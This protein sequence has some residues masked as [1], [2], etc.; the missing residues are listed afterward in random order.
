[1]SEIPTQ[2]WTC[3]DAEAMRFERAWKTG[4][5][6]QIEDFLANVPE[7]Q[8]SPLLTELLLIERELRVAAGELPT[9]KEYCR[10]FPEHDTVVA[11]AFERD[12]SARS[13]QGRETILTPSRALNSTTQAEAKEI[14]PEL[15]SNPDYEIVRSL[16]EGGMG[17]VYL[18]HNRVMGRDEVLKVIG[19][20]II[21]QPGVSDRFL[22]EI[23]AVAKLRHPNIVSAYSTFRCGESLVFAMEYVEGLDL[24]RLVKANGPLPIANASN[25]IHQAALGLQHAHEEGM[26][27]R[28]IKPGNLMLSSKGKRAVIKLLDF[29]LARA[30]RE[31]GLA[32]Q[33]LDESPCS[34]S[35]RLSLTLSG[36]MLGTPDFMAPEQ[37]VDAQAADIR[38]DIYSLG[39][40]LFCLLTGRAPFEGAMADVLRAHRSIEAPLLDEVR[41]DVPPALADLVAK[42]LAKSPDDRPQAPADVAVGLTPFFTA[43]SPSLRTWNLAGL[44]FSTPE[45]A[46]GSAEL[47]LQ[48]TAPVDPIETPQPEP[49]QLAPAETGS[50]ERIQSEIRAPSGVVIIRQPK[51]RFRSAIAVP[52]AMIFA[53]VVLLAVSNQRRATIG[54]APD[55]SVEHPGAPDET[56]HARV[57]T[58]E[59]GG[60][61][62]I[63]N[64]HPEQISPSGAA[65]SKAGAKKQLSAP[66]PPPEQPAIPVGPA[67]RA[68]DPAPD[69]R[70]SEK[71]S[72]A[73]PSAEVALKPDTEKRSQIALP[74]PGPSQPDD[75][76]KARGLTRIGPLYI[77]DAERDFLKSLPKIT[78]LYGEVKARFVQLAAVYQSWAEYDARNFEYKDLLAR[79]RAIRA[80]IEA[81][82]PNTNNLLKQELLDLEKRVK[83]QLNDLD[84]ELDF[85]YSKLVGQNQCETLFGEFQEKRA[86]FLKESRSLRARGDEIKGRYQALSKDDTLTS[87]IKEQRRSTKT[88]LDL[89]PSQAFTTRSV[90]LK[91]AEMDFSD[92]RLMRRRRPRAAHSG[93][94]R[95]SS[96]ATNSGAR[97]EK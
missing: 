39:C 5:R 82:P 51:H 41:P 96:A 1:M 17:L 22:R 77:L 64:R 65:V 12:P 31:Q 47:S 85:R 16:G 69:V 54:G 8:R 50:P 58:S 33:C 49:Q 70:V 45:P 4:P 36:E 34:D 27:H 59:P 52:S 23:R 9:A 38:A 80:E 87:A 93:S 37:I 40:T 63:P 60:S 66:V 68:N 20:K 73:P 62:P 43:G 74:T 89:G 15:A 7:R 2:Q 75:V 88:S 57:P 21:G 84:R 55:V 48:T 81:V 61:P 28:D 67:P 26:V 3:I 83:V 42:M 56:A 92:Q 94:E 30:S 97:T 72:Q 44:P 19:P 32:A 76:F 78:P 29:G 95:A 13:P 79:S 71:E 25:Y 10:R 11:A 35:A 53:A 24:S 86:E 91:K 90:E 14:P 6:P 46:L 18:A